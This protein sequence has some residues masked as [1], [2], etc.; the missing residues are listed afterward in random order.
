ME[1]CRATAVALLG[2][3]ATNIHCDIEGE[4]PSDSLKLSP[5][6]ERVPRRHFRIKPKVD[7]TPNPDRRHSRAKRGRI[8]TGVTDLQVDFESDHAENDLAWKKSKDKGRAR[9]RQSLKFK[10][11][12]SQRGFRGHVTQNKRIPDDLPLFGKAA[13]LAARM[14]DRQSL[15]NSGKFR[16]DKARKKRILSGKEFRRKT[17]DAPKVDVVRMLELFMRKGTLSRS[18]R[19]RDVASSIKSRVDLV[20][21]LD[22]LESKKNDGKKIT[23]VLTI[24]MVQNEQGLDPEGLLQ[25][26]ELLLV[27]AGIEKNPGP[28]TVSSAD[29][30]FERKKEKIARCGGN[31]PADQERIDKK[32]K[33]G[34]KCFKNQSLLKEAGMVDK[35]HELA[36]K[37]VKRDLEEEQEEQVRYL[38]SRENDVNREGFV[39]RSEGFARPWYDGF[40]T[41]ETYAALL[42]QIFAFLQRLYVYVR[43]RGVLPLYDPRQ[44]DVWRPYNSRDDEKFTPV[45]KGMVYLVGLISVSWMILVGGGLVMQLIA[46]VSSAVGM[47]MVGI[48]IQFSLY[49]MDLALLFIG[50]HLSFR[51]L[52]RYGKADRMIE[53]GLAKPFLL[54]DNPAYHD[55][56]RLP[57]HRIRKSIDQAH[58]ARVHGHIVTVADSAPWFMQFW[59]TSWLFGNLFTWLECNRLCKLIHHEREM[60]ISLKMVDSIAGAL[61]KSRLRTY[62]EVEAKARSCASSFDQLRLGTHPIE[63]RN[64]RE[65][66]VIY[67][68]AHFW[69]RLASDAS[70]GE[71]DLPHSI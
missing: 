25:L 21:V 12:R 55:D 39:M 17:A 69:A 48:A 13:S 32:K 70:L 68:A 42:T 57:E 23:K 31:L 34:K 53:F 19:Y 22:D 71:V 16:K 1:A 38:A 61:I 28:D 7:F 29:I 35:D 49:G 41:P 14:T 15:R 59:S 24:D 45:F 52:A 9:L 51:P 47:D 58:L 4:I 43:H 6:N 63:G 20:K 60:V 11:E 67:A 56:Q 62:L 66:S 46:L 30:S 37:D 3:A 8:T 64:V 27:R 33:Q 18:V 50:F 65:D 36:E 40:G 10:K 26:L 5:L 2:S 54:T 44:G